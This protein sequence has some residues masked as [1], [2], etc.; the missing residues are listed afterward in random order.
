VDMSG[1]MPQVHSADLDQSV[2][3]AIFP[4]FRATPRAFFAV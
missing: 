4:T 3:S 1:A 2:P